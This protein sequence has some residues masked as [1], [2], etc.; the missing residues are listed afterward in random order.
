MG[1][2]TTRNFL[3]TNAIENITAIPKK[4]MQ[5]YVDSP[6]GASHKLVGSGLLPEFIHKKDYGRA[7]GYLEVRRQEMDQAQADYERFRVIF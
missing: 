7:P 6:Q 4:P 2:K 5:K 1:K 3:T